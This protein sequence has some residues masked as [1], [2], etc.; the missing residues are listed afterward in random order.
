MSSKRFFLSLISAL[1][2]LVM[3]F[4]VGCANDN[5][6]DVNT[7]G[8]ENGDVVDNVDVTADLTDPLSV[9]S[10]QDLK[11]WENADPAPTDTNISKDSFAIGETLYSPT[12]TGSGNGVPDGW[13][14]VPDALVSWS[15]GGRSDG[16]ADYSGNDTDANEAINTKRFTYTDT[17]LKATIG[18][19]DFVLLMPTLKDS[20]GREVTDYLYTVKATFAEGAKGRIGVTTG[21]RGSEVTYKG[22]TFFCYYGPEDSSSWIRFHY[23]KPGGTI[24]SKRTDD[25]DA[26][27][28]ATPVAGEQFTISVYHSGGI[29]YFYL[30]DQLVHTMADRDYYDGA[31]LSGVGLYLSNTTVTINEI[32]INKI[33]PKIQLSN[34]ALTEPKIAIDLSA[35][36]ADGLSFIGKVDKSEYYYADNVSGKYDLANDKVELGM[37]VIAKS[38]IPENGIVLA[39]TSGVIHV[40]AD[41]V[42]LEDESSLVYSATLKN[43]ADAD[44]DK[45]YLARAYAKVTDG[46]TPVYYYSKT[47][48]LRSYAGVANI[49]YTDCE[50]T[51]LRAI[52]DETFSGCDSYIGGN[53][54]T[55]SFS[56]FSDFHYSKGDNIIPIS[57]LEEIMKKANDKDVNFVMQ[58]GDFC[59][60]FYGSPE[61]FE[62]YLNNKYNLPVYGTLGNH[63]LE[64][65]TKTNSM[66]VVVPMLTNQK[67]KVVWGSKNGRIGDGSIA[68]YHFDSDVD[69]DGKADFRIVSCDTNHFL[70]EKT[71]TWDHYPAWY[72]NP[73][74]NASYSIYNALG[75]V[76][77]A[78][79]QKV[80]TDAADKDLPCIVF[81]HAGLSGNLG[82]SQC[83]DYKEVQ[84][85]F[86][87]ANDKNPG[88]VLMAIN[89]HHH[90]NH[91]EYVD[92]ILYVDLNSSAGPYVPDGSNKTPNYPA[93][94]SFEYTEYDAAGKPIGTTTKLIKDLNGSGCEAYWLAGPLS[95]VVHVSS[96]GRIVLEGDSAE[97][98][99]EVVNPNPADGEDSFINSGVFNVAAN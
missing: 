76:Q 97:W 33:S 19:G 70:N 75:E 48:M 42:L 21:T 35:N 30:G 50:S 82:S 8:G 38:D 98:Y 22:S 91:T 10:W 3:L 78:W 36:K 17:G 93:N 80:L 32:T 52:L 14:A 31:P 81:A 2:A 12:L 73:G 40:K 16:W 9:N 45:V 20:T 28:I 90:T 7:P 29:N 69:G 86:K 63:D 25:P 49:Y 72:S 34:I 87:K 4:S 24:S 62:A 15:N 84:E 44:K 23:G 61:L 51:K 68:Y 88:T 60:D 74:P 5:N 55:I 37:L 85:I 41:K 66:K 43:I 77:R 58:V 79:L 54:K 53:A 56:V 96:N 27:A 99:L 92:G 46:T 64:G 65:K 83:G 11:L 95:T 71:G 6:D 13:L 47:Q 1:L 94:A 89:G 57:Y 59:E 67:D 18:G 39:D 26:A